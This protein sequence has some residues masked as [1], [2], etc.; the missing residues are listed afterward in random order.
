MSYFP[1]PARAID[2]AQKA[3]ASTVGGLS[4]AL[5]GKANASDVPLPAS[6]VPPSEA[7]GGNMGSSNSRF[8]RED[9]QHPRVSSTTYVTLDVSGQATVTFS[10]AFTNKPGLNL[11]ETDAPASSQPLIL[12]GLAW[13]RDAQNRY[14]GVV[15]Q[16]MRAQQI[17]QLTP[18]AGL[19]TAIITGV[20]SVVT[21][22]TGFNVFGGTAIG[23]TVSVI[24]VGRSDVAST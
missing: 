13:T 21:T 2:L 24:A 23:A 12:R 16:G 4:T 3:N 7:I 22:L 19:L 18:V 1:D 9:H 20:N 11:T 17:P 6:I 10:R 8:A 14:T 5:N 15:I